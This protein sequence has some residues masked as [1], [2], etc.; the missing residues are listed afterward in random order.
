MTESRHVAETK[1]EDHKN[2]IAKQTYQ[3]P[4]DD[5][6][7][8]F[9]DWID[10]GCPMDDTIESVEIDEA[11]DGLFDESLEELERDSIE[12]YSDVPSDEMI[13][14]DPSDDNYNGLENYGC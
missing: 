7:V 2:E 4:V 3:H 10:A 11:V 14:L 6:S 13:H 12:D 8:A 5:S 1:T 9:T